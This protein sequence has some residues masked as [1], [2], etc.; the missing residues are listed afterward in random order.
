MPR[1]PNHIINCNNKRTENDP[2]GSC[3]A[4]GSEGLLDYAKER[5]N[6]L[7]LKGEVRVNKAGCLDACSHGPTMVIYPGDTWYAPK[8]KKDI[9]EIITSHIQ[10]KSIA[11][12]L[13]IKFK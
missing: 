10:N 7:G 5:I 4:R 1:F 11:D 12:R 13:I 8:T 3:S 2:R 6:K 9:E